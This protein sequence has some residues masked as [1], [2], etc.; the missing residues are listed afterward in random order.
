[1]ENN[2]KNVWTAIGCLSAGNPVTGQV[3]GGPSFI[4]QVLGWGVITGVGVA[5]LLIVFAGF[6]MATSA[7]DPK[8]FGSATELLW[9]AISG[10][11]LILFS[12]FLLNLIGVKILNLPGFLVPQ[13]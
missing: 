1:M 10:L 12:L 11:L 5:F 9:S 4:G 7:G 2:P 8:R 13:P 3:A 6:T